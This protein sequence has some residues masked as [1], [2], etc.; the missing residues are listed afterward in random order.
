MSQWLRTF[1]SAVAGIQ[2]SRRRHSAW[3]QSTA[4]LGDYIA[5]TRL[6]TGH[7]IYVDTRDIGIASHLMMDGRWEPW[8]ERVLVKALKPGMTFC[9]IGANFGYYTLIGASAVGARGRVFA[10]ECNPR[11]F[12]LL[13]RSV[14]VNGLHEIVELSPLAVSGGMEQATLTYDNK[15]SGGG[16]ILEA[17]PD[18][19]ETHNK[20]TVGCASLDSLLSLQTSPN[21]LKVDVE[22]SEPL[23]FEGAHRILSDRRLQTIIFEYYAP[24]ISRSISPTALLN[25]LS[26]HDFHLQMLPPTGLLPPCGPE[27]LV[28]AIGDKMVYVLATRP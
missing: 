11:L 3:S 14:L 13:N 2:R 21:V 26:G 25:Q 1:R 12:D 15:F 4:Y 16:T 27:E 18:S 5:L 8:V 24:S 20:I 9:D 6:H 19:S 10:F 22:G 7:K 17:G 23:V 28:E